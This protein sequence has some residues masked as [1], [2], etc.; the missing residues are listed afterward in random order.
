MTEITGNRATRLL[1]TL[2]F[3]CTFLLSSL[4]FGQSTTEGAIGGTVA[5]P[6]G[7][8]IP[9]ATITVKNLGSNLKSS[10]TTDAQGY[11]RVG[12]LS[13]AT[14]SVTVTATGF[15][16]FRAENVI[17]TVGSLTAVSPHLTI[18]TTEQVEVTAEVPLINVTSADFTQTLN[19]AAIENLPINGGRWSGF[20][21]LTPGVVSNSD[22]FGLL[23]FRGTSALLNNVTVDGA[24]NNQAFF[25][26]ERGRTRAGYSTAKASVQEFQVNTS[27]IR[28]NMDARLAASSIPSPRAVRTRSTAKHTGMTVTTTGAP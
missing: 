22:G 11:Y 6:Q 8:V 1:L 25:S 24:D 5:D 19:S 27:T 21:V 12:Q 9:G 2:L 20:T 10:V 28:L 13:P 23:S 14:Y 16:P 4:A 7:N 26:E 17:V 15:A 3:C 18:G